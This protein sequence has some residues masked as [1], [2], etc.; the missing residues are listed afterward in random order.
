VDDPT[1]VIPPPLPVNVTW[2][3]EE[4]VHSLKQVT[5]KQK[6]PP[7]VAPQ[8]AES[9]NL[10]L[11][12]HYIGDIHQPLHAVTRFDQVNK[13]GDEGGNYF[14]IEQVPGIS[15]LHML[16]DSVLTAFNLD[17]PQPLSEADFNFLSEHAER[18]RKTYPPESLQEFFEVPRTLWY[19]EGV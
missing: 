15:N 4:M 7:N 8:L 5:S 3:I 13:D 2:A 16:W 17:L 19:E 14:T 9:F 6:N 10:R 11:L 1:I 12:I 18:I